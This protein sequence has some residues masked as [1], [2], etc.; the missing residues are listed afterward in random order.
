MGEAPI[1]TL[2]TTSSDVDIVP[3]ISP[4]AGS[5]AGSFSFLYV[6]S[7]GDATKDLSY[8]S[9]TA[10]SLGNT[11]EVVDENGR[12]AN[13]TLPEGGFSLSGTGV[14][15]ALV[16][17]TS[18]IVVR[19]TSLSDDGVYYAGASIFIQVI[20]CMYWKFM[21]GVAAAD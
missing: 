11:T 15:G 5:F 4:L 8:A 1:L 3:C 9:P 10:L 13:I 14:E 21:G 2:A 6:V 17:D 19:V 12:V 7:P 18:N 16:V 20:C